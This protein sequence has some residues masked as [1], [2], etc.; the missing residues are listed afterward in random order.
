MKKSIYAALFGMGIVALVLTM[1]ATLWIYDI[2][3]QEEAEI[4]LRQVT[5][6][7]ADGMSRSEAPVEWL[8]TAINDVDHSLRMTWIDNTGTVQYE[9]AYHA[10]HMDNHNG[11]PEIQQARIQGEG[12]SQRESGTLSRETSYYAVRL[13]DGSILRG[14]LD[15]TG[16]EAIYHKMVPSLLAI[17]VVMLVLCFYLARR[18]T[19]YL[20]RPLREAGDWVASTVEGK[21]VPLLMGVPELDPILARAREQQENIAQYVCQLREERNRNRLMMDTLKEGVVL[22]N[23]DGKMIDFNLAARDIFGLTRAHLGQDIQ[24]LDP[25]KEWIDIM[26][27]TMDDNNKVKCTWHHREKVYR[28]IMRRAD[29]GQSLLLVVRDM[30]ADDRAEKQRREFSANVTHEINTPLTSIRGFAE[31]LRNGMYQ[32]DNEVKDF[33]ERILKESDR[34]LILIEKVMR[35]SRI[36]EQPHRESWQAVSLKEMA[37][38]VVDLLAPQREKKEVQMRVVGETGTVYGDAQLLFELV[39]N[40]ADN[41]IKYNV[42]GGK[43]ELIVT[44]QKDTVS[45]TCRDTGIGIPEASQGHVF[46]RFYR[47]EESRSKDTGGSGIGLAIVK[48]I[49]QSHQGRLDLRSTPGE[50][51]VITVSFPRVERHS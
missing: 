34:L 50:G 47:V 3:T 13:P 30:T 41:A 42:P 31:L 1:T 19:A 37:E 48:H 26:E 28:V 15:R 14:A 46:E 2:T 32:T 27:Q 29:D 12:I 24:Q 43:V 38:Q 33:S 5:K 39:L 18:L 45:L 6:V 21:K 51:T 16:W 36:E 23:G 20:L 40:I 44:E 17:V 8:K 7:L 35:L 11:R 10:A 9:S 25:D 49:A 4:H 22:I